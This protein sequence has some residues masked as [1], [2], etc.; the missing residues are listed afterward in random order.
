M[1]A[2]NVLSIV[3]AGITLLS[4]VFNSLPLCIIGLCLVGMAYGASPTVGS[5]FASSFYGQKHFATNYSII[6][7]SLMAASFIATACSKLLVS[8]GSYVA[9]FT[10]LLALAS[11]A[12]FINLSI[13]RP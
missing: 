3:A 1:I 13:R 5:A 2:A 4:T 9:P 11:G 10:L 8:S 6:N 7:F 12:L